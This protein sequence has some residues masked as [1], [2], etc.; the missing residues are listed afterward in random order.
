M[1][2]L[3]KT[4]VQRVSLQ[5]AQVL[6]RYNVKSLRNYASIVNNQESSLDQLISQAH[7]CLLNGDVDNALGHFQSYLQRDKSNADVYYNI[8]NVYFQ[9]GDLD[10]AKSNWEQSLSIKS[11]SDAYTN[12]GNFYLMFD[13]GDAQKSSQKAIEYYK[14][15]TELDPQ[16]GEILFNLGLAYDRNGDHEN[17][18]QTL[19][20]SEEKLSR[21][22]DE[23]SDED[24]YKSILK[25]KIDA[26]KVFLRNTQIKLGTNIKKE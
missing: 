22:C 7:D 14:K 16:D 21:K 9:K 17:A 3:N 18:L 23:M 11:S 6:K 15:A 24:Q 2:R 19:Q 26:V 13:Q 12:L 10:Q 8:G 5:S 25:Q 1:L 20:A 4:V